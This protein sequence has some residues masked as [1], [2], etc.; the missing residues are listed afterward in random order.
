MASIAWRVRPRTDQVGRAEISAWIRSRRWPLVASALVV[1]SALV[2]SVAWGPLVQHLSYWIV[3]ADLWGTFRS[4]HYVAWGDIG[5][6]YAVQTGL[7]TFP[8]ISVLLAPV[9]WLSSHFALT[10][11]IPPFPVPH[12]QAWLLLGPVELLAGSVVLFPLDRIA[13]ELGVRGRQRALLC[14]LEGAL[15]WPVLAIWGHPED[16]LAMAFGAWGLLAAQRGSWRSCGWLL[17]VALAIQ[18]LVVVVFPIVFALAPIRQWLPLSVRAV[19]PSGALLTIPLVQEWGLT[20]RALF[21]QPNYPSLDHATPW[22]A[23]APVLSKPGR[24]ISQRVARIRTHGLTHFTVVT[25][26]VVVGPVVAAGP[27]RLIAVGL[28][29]GVGL[30]VWRRKPSMPQVIWAAGVALSLRCFFEAVMDPFYLWP[31]LAFLAIVAIGGRRR[32][33]ITLAGSGFVTWWSYHHIGPWAWWGPIAGVLVVL[34]VA[35]RPT[36]DALRAA[37]EPAPGAVEH[38]DGPA[39]VPVLVGP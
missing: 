16:P 22:L 12:P 5:D 34:V 35:A 23:L 29:L 36:K 20:T 7:V 17:G 13:G 3:P 4:A 10:E 15:L 38:C 26:H 2:Y 37:Q 30:W 24:A 18:P 1:V 9:A 14:V 28:A 19:L 33:A 25:R 6:V 39:M 8:G 27:G 31:P 11:A 32:F 21:K